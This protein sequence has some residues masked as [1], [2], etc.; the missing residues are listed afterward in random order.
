MLKSAFPRVLGAIILFVGSCAPSM[1][2]G[3]L[4]HARCG[5]AVAKSLVQACWVGVVVGAVVV[6]RPPQLQ[7][8]QQHGSVV[9]S[10]ID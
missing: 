5:E 10:G 4:D 9:R 1:D 3:G 6:H 7:G 2:C 8:L